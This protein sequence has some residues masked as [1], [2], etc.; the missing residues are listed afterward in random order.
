MTDDQFTGFVRNRYAALV[1]YGALLMADP[2]H[3]EDLAQEALI[4]TYRAWSRLFPDG[5]PEAYTRT[6]MAR[7]AWRAG[8]RR[9]RH[10]VPSA[11]LPELSTPDSHAE[12]DTAAMV[13][14]ALR[15]LPRQQRIVLV[16]RFWADLSEREMAEMLDCSAGTVKSRT[17]RAIATLRSNGGLL[18]E[19]L[20]DLLPMKS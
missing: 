16:L 3:G 2:G 6:V 11:A 4:K 8:R 14:A 20:D 1:R 15:M 12:R 9:W 19:A 13:F 5:D 18:A 10:E 7:A 17:S